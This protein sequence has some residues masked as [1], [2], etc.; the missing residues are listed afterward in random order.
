MKESTFSLGNPERI[1]QNGVKWPCV[2]WRFRVFIAL[3]I[4]VFVN[5]KCCPFKCFIELYFLSWLF[6]KISFLSCLSLCCCCFQ[7]YMKIAC[8]STQ[9]AA[10]SKFIWC[11][12][13]KMETKMILRPLQTSVHSNTRKLALQV[14]RLTNFRSGW[15]DGWLKLN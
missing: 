12:R 13:G 10:C 2:Y 3:S 8:S 7:S 15:A 14:W 6:A 9:N 4:H 11:F 1:H 5:R